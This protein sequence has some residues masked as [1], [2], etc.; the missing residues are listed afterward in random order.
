LYN[1]ERQAK[2]VDAQIGNYKS[3]EEERK[4]KRAEDADNK[5]TAAEKAYEKKNQQFRQEPYITN[6]MKQ[7]SA[8]GL[9]PESQLNLIKD[10]N[11]QKRAYFAAEVAQFPNLKL[12]LLDETQVEP[13]K[14]PPG[15]S[16]MQRMGESARNAVSGGLGALSVAPGMGLPRPNITPQ[17]APAPRPNTVP[18]GQLPK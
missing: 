13:T 15:P 14:P 10:Y 2:L 12:P 11:R 8:G 1:A 7:L 6:I 5:P 9:D 17:Q 3:L 4:A 16:F 18:F